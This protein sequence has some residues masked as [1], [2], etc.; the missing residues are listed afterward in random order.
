MIFIKDIDDPRISEFRELKKLTV[1]GYYINQFIAD[2]DKVVL[3]AIN[4]DL[5]GIKLLAK[6]DFIDENIDAILNKFDEDNIFTSDKKILSEIIGFKLHTG[7]MAL[8]QT[9][10]HQDI[11]NLDEQI[12]A[13]NKIE[14][15][16]NIGAI[17][18]SGVGFGLNSYIFDKQSCHPFMRKSVRISMGSAFKIKYNISEDLI[19]NLKILKS[20]GYEII[21]VEIHNNSINLNNF[22]F[23]SKIVL[24]FGSESNG[25]DSN[26]LNLSDKI[27]EIPI[28]NNIDSLNVNATS[29]IIFNKILNDN[30]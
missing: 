27:I 19:D 20:I 2:G 15:A 7:V 13:F 24:I 4:S 23:N 21:A 14:R 6:Q 10:P 29:A 28:T 22:K 25:I 17:I 26:I 8:F 5:K 12:V 18:R 1:N 11:D 3:K 30:D 16:E 9:P